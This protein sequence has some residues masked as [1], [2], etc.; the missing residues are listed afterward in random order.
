MICATY[1]HVLLW[2]FGETWLDAITIHPVKLNLSKRPWRPGNLV[3]IQLGHHKILPGNAWMKTWNILKRWKVSFLLT[4]KR[5]QTDFWTIK[6]DWRNT[7]SKLTSQSHSIPPR[8]HCF[9]ISF[10]FSDE[11]PKGPTTSVSNWTVSPMLILRVP[12][13][14]G[15]W[16]VIACLMDFVMMRTIFFSYILFFECMSDSNNDLFNGY[17]N[18][19]MDEW[20]NEWPTDWLTECMNEG[21]SDF[22]LI[23]ISAIK[24]L[25]RM[26][27]LS[28]SHSVLH[29]WICLWSRVH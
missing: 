21:L 15:I 1:I 6:G 11:W 25:G 20:K 29:P 13:S 26:S 8:C 12:L 27:P 16:H 9:S 23:N 19:W 17:M 14:W 24:W 18:G 5:C 28:E 3:N 10:F 22:S 4:W 7:M 2:Y